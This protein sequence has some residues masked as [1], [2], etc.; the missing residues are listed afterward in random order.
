MRAEKGGK[1]LRSNKQGTVRFK[2]HA[3]CTIV[4]HEHKMSVFTHAVI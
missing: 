2:G 4:K 3:H 1:E